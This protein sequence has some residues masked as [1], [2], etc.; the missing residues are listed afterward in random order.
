[1]VQQTFGKDKERTIKLFRSPTLETVNMVESV[2]KEYSG[3]YK[4][5]GLWGKLPK[6][7]MWSTYLIILDYLEEI[8]KIIVSD[9][10]ILVYIWDN[11]GIKKYLARKSY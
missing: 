9:N 5:T 7:I 8:N 11:V 6:K 2:I 4:K 1:M 3:E 10:G